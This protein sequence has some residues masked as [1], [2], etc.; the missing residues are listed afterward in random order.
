MREHSEYMKKQGAYMRKQGL[1][2]GNLSA[3]V[4]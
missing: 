1:K 2:S 4:D 3:I